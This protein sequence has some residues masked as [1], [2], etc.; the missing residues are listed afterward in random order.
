MLFDQMLI[1]PGKTRIRP[2]VDSSRKSTFWSN[3]ISTVSN[4]CYYSRQNADSEIINGFHNL[5]SLEVLSF[6]FIRLI[7]SLHD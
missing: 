4:L 2:N 6:S 7:A 1:S 5:I 3:N